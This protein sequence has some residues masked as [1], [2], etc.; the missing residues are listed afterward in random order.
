MIFQ[1]STPLRIDI[2]GGVTDIPVLK[3]VFGTSI[4]NIGID[5][6]ADELD[7]FVESAGSTTYRRRKKTKGAEPDTSFYLGDKAR[8][9]LGIGG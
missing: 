1:I 7:L 6:Y 8:K 3:D 2:G 4:F 9:L 5:V